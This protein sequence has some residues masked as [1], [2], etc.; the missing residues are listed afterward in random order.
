M[1]AVEPTDDGLRLAGSIL[2]F[3]SCK[4]GQLSFLSS[5][6]KPETYRGP[7]FLATEETVKILE[8]Y[9]KKPQKV[10]ICQYNRP[11]AVGRL[12]IELLPS[13]V[14]LGGAL[15]LIENE[16]NKLLYV[17]AIQNKKLST[18]RQAQLVNADVLVLGADR[19][20]THGLVPSRKKEVERL[21]TAIQKYVNAGTCPVLFCE[22]TGTAQE[23]TKLINAMN[24]PL[25]VHASIHKINMIYESFHSKLGEYEVFTRK[26]HKNKV[27]LFP[28]SDLKYFGRMKSQLPEA[29]ILYVEDNIADRFQGDF[30][31][32]VNEKFLIDS[33]CQG[34]ELREVI[35]KVAP[36]ITYVFGAYAKQYASELKGSCPSVVALYAHHQPTLF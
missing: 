8:V 33:V 27:L 14:M 28:L 29:P 30:S 6:S 5:A 36:K 26:L 7:Q 21:M 34:K 19:P 3:D 17:K 31:F 18:V 25:A 22:P 10:L 16:G 24:I 23:L 1:V 11:F 13:G 20:F 9:K 35:Q 32:S 2:W 4:T 12:K 15:L